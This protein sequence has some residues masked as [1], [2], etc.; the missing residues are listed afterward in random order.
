VSV[1]RALAVEVIDVDSVTVRD[2]DT[3][4]LVEVDRVAVLE[5]LWLVLT[6][7][8][9]DKESVRVDD[10]ELV[11]RALADGELDEDGET[12][13]DPV[14]DELLEEDCELLIIAL[15]LLVFVEVDEILA[16][17]D[18]IELRDPLT[19]NDGLLDEDRDTRLVALLLVEPVVDRDMSVALLRGLLVVDRDIVTLTVPLTLA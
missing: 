1:A 15:M 11:A 19:L 14:K 9:V 8:V 7:V 13:E 6:D 5:A 10:D 2:P 4:G 3:E 18:G 17:T 12:V 16:L